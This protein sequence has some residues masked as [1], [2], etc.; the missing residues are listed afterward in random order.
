MQSVGFVIC[1]IKIRCNS[2]S[3]WLPVKGARG[4]SLGTTGKPPEVEK[5]CRVDRLASSVWASADSFCTASGEKQMKMATHTFCLLTL[6]QLS[7][8]SGASVRNADDREKHS[9]GTHPISAWQWRL[10]KRMH[11]CHCQKSISQYRTP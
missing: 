1:S 3:V 8:R 7:H 11:C 10:F 4:T 2:K 6:S 9:T 5:R